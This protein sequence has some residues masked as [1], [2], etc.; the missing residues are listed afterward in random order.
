MTY[1]FNRMYDKMPCFFKLISGNTTFYLF[2]GFFFYPIFDGFV[3]S[4]LTGEP[5]IRS[6]AGT[7]VQCFYNYLKLLDSGWSL[8]ALRYGAGMTVLSR[9]RLL[10]LHQSL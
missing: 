1:H 6:G 3:K 4:H 8:P 7:V 2:F 10:R 9:F 5:R